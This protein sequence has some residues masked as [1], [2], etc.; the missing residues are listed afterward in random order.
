[1]LFSSFLCAID[2]IQ[3]L[4]DDGIEKPAGQITIIHFNDVYNIEERQ[5][6]PVGGSARFCT[7]VHSYTDEKPLVIFSGDS[8]N[9]SLMSTITKV[10]CLE[11]CQKIE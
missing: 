9:P 7:K 2:I 1:M 4:I 10:G 8:F 5:R 11:N 3:V 6:E